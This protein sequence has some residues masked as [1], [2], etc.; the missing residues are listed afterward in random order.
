VRSVVAVVEDQYYF[1]FGPSNG[2]AP[3][4]GTVTTGTTQI[5]IYVPMAP[6]VIA[7]FSNFQF[8]EWG[9]SQTGAHSFDLEMGFWEK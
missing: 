7:P 5:T 4:G 6:V 3:T 1:N 2:A 9:T 8:S